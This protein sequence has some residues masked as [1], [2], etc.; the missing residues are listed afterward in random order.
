MLK[1]VAAES[2]V[3]YRQVRELLVELT[4]WDRSPRPL[5]H[6]GPIVP[7]G[8]YYASGDEALPGEYAPPKGRMLLGTYSAKAAGCAAFHRMTPDICEMKRMYVRPALLLFNGMAVASIY[9][10]RRKLPNVV[11]PY[12]VW[13]YPVVPALFLA[14]T[15]YLMI[16]TFLAAPQRAFA[17]LGIV[18]LGLPLYA[19]YAR[20]L[21]PIRP[22][23]WLIDK[24]VAGP[25]V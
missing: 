12:R 19:Y 8:T 7:P 5:A 18:A 1:I 25:K 11:R 15:A 13:G 24:V 16:N 17:S 4:E 22:E 6:R 21:P 10:L 20:R 14:A 23:D 2:Q 3:Q 9:V